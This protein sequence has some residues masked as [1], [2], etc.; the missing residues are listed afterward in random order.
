LEVKCGAIVC[1]MISKCC[2]VNPAVHAEVRGWKLWY[3][4][5]RKV[6][7]TWYR[8]TFLWIKYNIFHIGF[9]WTMFLCSLISGKQFKKNFYSVDFDLINWDYSL[10]WSW[11]RFAYIKAKS[12]GNSPVGLFKD[13]F[14]KLS[15]NWPVIRNSSRL[16]PS[17]KNTCFFTWGKARG[18]P[19]DWH[20]KSS[21]IHPPPTYEVIYSQV[22]TIGTGHRS[23]VF[24]MYLWFL[25]NP[26]VKK[27]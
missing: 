1:R 4:C 20:F 13:N 24:I 25:C 8:S 9:S 21:Y 10:I 27:H 17:E 3:N 22:V 2:P 15:C 26:R 19:D 11:K 16:F 12:N 18:V 6:R 23:L 14:I 5:L 7:N